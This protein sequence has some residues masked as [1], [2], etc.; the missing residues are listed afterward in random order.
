MVLLWF[1][2]PCRA[3]LGDLLDPMLISGEY[4]LLMGKVDQCWWQG[5]QYPNGSSTWDTYDT[6]INCTTATK[7]ACLFNI[8]TD[9][10]ARSSYS[11]H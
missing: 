8:I 11:H 6:W 3:G 7:K 1:V 10:C 2:R 4:K 5:P 9:P